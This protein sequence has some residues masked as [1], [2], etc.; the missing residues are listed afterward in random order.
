MF[1]LGP[2]CIPPHSRGGSWLCAA[3]CAQPSTPASRR[4]HTAAAPSCRAGPG[5]SETGGTT[6]F[7]TRRACSVGWLSLVLQVDA[8]VRGGG[9]CQAPSILCCPARS[10]THR[11]C[12]RCA[13]RGAALCEGCDLEV[14]SWP[15]RCV[16][17]DCVVREGGD[18]G[19]AVWSGAVGAAKQWNEG[20]QSSL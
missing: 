5:R 1:A 6:A 12:E 2:R 14:T 8:E 10:V 13:V 20:L 16:T 11:T 3:V 17:T 9:R 19:G 7:C 4:A 18:A 15:R